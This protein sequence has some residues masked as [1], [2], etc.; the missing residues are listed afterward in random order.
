MIAPN[1][2]APKL[3]LLAAIPALLHGLLSGVAFA[4]E[5]VHILK[6]DHIVANVSISPDGKLIATGSNSYKREGFGSF[7]L[8]DA[9]AGKAIRRLAGYKFAM[10][11]LKFTPE[12]KHLVSAGFCSAIRIT[13]VSTGEDVSVI[14]KLDQIIRFDLLGSSG[15][16][17]ICHGDKERAVWDISDPA[18]P[19][20]AD[21]PPVFGKNVGPQVLS[22]DGKLIVGAKNSAPL[23]ELPPTLPPDVWI[24]DVAAGKK[25]KGFPASE[26]QNI[27]RLTLSP[28]K[29]VLAIG[30]VFGPRDL[31]IRRIRDG[32]V[33]LRNWHPAQPAS[34]AFSPDGKYLAVGSAINGELHIWDVEKG[35]AARKVQA[36]SGTVQCLAFSPNGELLVSGSAD[37]TAKIWKFADLK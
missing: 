28:D 21:N 1:N 9:R 30:Y 26:G 29:S 31:E 18:K 20:P 2:T 8:W 33:L 6:H 12:G 22:D 25:V 32:K 10:A 4:Q 15:L 16:L 34:M 13:K 35:V 37:H 24:W 7:V 17:A 14:D 11:G 5:P 27:L 36:H 19:K 3:F 23:D